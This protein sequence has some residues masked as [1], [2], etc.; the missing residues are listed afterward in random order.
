MTTQISDQLITNYFHEYKKEGSLT[1]EANAGSVT[2]DALVDKALDKWQL[3]ET[4]T[5]SGLYKL[6]INSGQ[7]RFTCQNGAKF[8]FSDA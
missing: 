3:I 2:V 1:V 4:F 5:E 6:A 8:T 7:F